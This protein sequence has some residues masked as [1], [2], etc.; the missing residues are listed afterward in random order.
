MSRPIVRLLLLVL[1]FSAQA[2]CALESLTIGVFA[3]RDK[4]ETVKRFQ[5]LV[6]YLERTLPGQRFMLHAY[7]YDEMETAIERRQVDFVLSHAAHYVTMSER[8]ALSSPLA[9][10]IEREKGQPLPVYGGTIIVRADRADITKL[11]DLKGRT[12]A[13]SSIK[14][15]ASYQMQAYEVHKLGLEIPGDVKVIE[16]ELPIDRAVTAVV[17]GKADAAFVRMGLLEQMTRE[18][19][20]DPAQV[21]VINAQQLAGFGYAVSTTLYPQWPFVAMPQVS[22]SLAGRVAAALLMLPHD[23]EV[24]RAAH[25]WG[26]SIPANYGPVRDVMQALRVPPFDVL[27]EFS[28]RDVWQRYTVTILVALASVALIF[29]LLVW[30]LLNRRRLAI[31]RRKVLQSSRYARSLLEA[32][33]DPLVTISAEGK[34]M[35]VNLATELATG[36]ARSRL[37]GSDFADYFTEPERARAGYRRVWEDGSIR[38]YPLAL[39]QADGGIME[40]LYN[41]TLYRDEHG[42]ALG[43]FAAARDVTERKRAEAEL[44]GYR[45]HLEELVAVRTAEL[46]KAKVAAEAANRAKSVFLANMSHELRTP[47][48]AILGFA[49]LMERDMAIPERERRNLETINRSGRHLL[50]L[51]NDVLEISR[52]EAGRTTVE[53]ETFDLAATLTA[54]EEMIRVR[55]EGKGLALAIERHGELPAYVLG[56]DHHL[57]QVLINLLGNAVKYTDRGQVTLHL[58]PEGERIRFEVTDTGPGIAPEDQ[59]RIFNAFY[60]TEAGIAKGEGTGLGLTI[61]REFVRLMGGELTVRSE[62]GKGSAF[63][64]AV[65]LPPTFIPAD[66]MRCGRVVGLEPGQPMPRILVAEDQP[67][68]RELITQ[69]LEGVGFE[70]RAVKNGQQAIEV[71]QAWQPQFIWMDMRMPIMDGYVATQRIRALPGGAAVKIVALTASAFREDRAAILAAGCDEMI[72]KPIEEDRLFGV[73]G[74]LLG[75]RF[76][77]AVEAGAVPVATPAA[78]DL[79]GLPDELKVELAQAAR[80]LDREASLAIVERFRPTYPGEANAIT[81]LVNG[82]RFDRVSELCQQGAGGS[83]QGGHLK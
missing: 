18:G 53:N 3:F 40:V 57:R 48:N 34:I 72:R 2:A 8:S 54:V 16:V 63:S 80:M 36:Q 42:E 64:F 35:D 39:R 61:S 77:Y 50:S 24:A 9:T 52:I 33:L 45:H 32:S 58:T 46:E 14:G 31:E 30:L 76:S 66:A 21:K 10:L 22:D 62:L 49:Q 78:L 70:V 17:E 4:A 29:L 15:F 59:D 55:A 44:E 26:F 47:L 27:P 37:V 60:Q 68:N 28:W 82:Y 13:T 43:A 5:P 25:L 19:K 75:L 65:P 7:T 41:A 23:G 56:D 11:A 73:M 20:L 71:F 83:P 67:D 74:D 81:D 38:D 69:L 6:A 51:I 1:L 12:V 79:G